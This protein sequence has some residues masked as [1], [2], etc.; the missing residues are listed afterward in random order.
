MSKEFTRKQ[1]RKVKVLISK[2]CANF[3]DNECI[4]LDEGD[5]CVCVQNISDHMMCNYFR[6]SVLPN[7]E[8]LEKELTGSTSK[9]RCVMCNKPFIKKSN[10]HRYCPECAKLRRSMKNAQYQYR[11]KNRVKK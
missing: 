1:K 6:N 9:E 5:G 2:Y 11:H 10:R 4:A 3:H 8:A 7:D